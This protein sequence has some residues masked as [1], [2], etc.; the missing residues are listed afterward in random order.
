MPDTDGQTPPP[1]GTP[2]PAPAAPAPATPAAT[3]AATGMIQVPA[4]EFKTLLADRQIADAA[5]QAEAQ[6]AAAAEAARLKAL[7]E[8]EGVDAALKLARDQADAEK[9]A[10][11]EELRTYQARLLDYHKGTELAR[12]LTG[13]VWTSAAAGRDATEKLSKLF[14]AVD[15]SGQVVTRQ[16]GTGR[17]P[18]EVIPELLKTEEFAHFVKA[19]STGGAGAAGTHRPGEAPKEETYPTEGH[20]LL[21]LLKPQLAPTGAGTERNGL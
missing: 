16:V 8:K 17:L 6:K 13:V 18:A 9:K 20:R 14:E 3:P 2:A 7:A 4:E 15:V 10:H 12:Q 1:A 11:Q 5:R 21:A 19:A